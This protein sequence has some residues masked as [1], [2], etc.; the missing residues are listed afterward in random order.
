M[1]HHEPVT[2]DLGDEFYGF[3]GKIDDT[4]VCATTPRVAHDA[5]ARAVVRDLVK[6]QGGDCALCQ[7]CPVAHL[8]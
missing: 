8:A 7:G 5:H 4:I 2:L 3:R 1:L 6:R